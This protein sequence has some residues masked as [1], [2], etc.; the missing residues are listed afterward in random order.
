M[1]NRAD[2]VNNAIRIATEKAVK[3]VHEKVPG[4]PSTTGAEYPFKS[5]KQ[6]LFVIISIRE[7]TL[8]VPYRRSGNLGASIASEV[9]TL[10][11]NYVGIIGSNKVY[12]PWVISNKP[13]G[14]RGPQ[15]A[16][17]KGNWY[18]LQ[19]IVFKAADAIRRIY[20]NEIMNILK[21]K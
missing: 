18:T 9:K 21:S 14:S 10:G 2:D 17:H 16:Y 5:L 3:H 20:E 1:K 7:G 19:D 12:A 11:K 4:Y 13:V 15:A 8:T 6:L